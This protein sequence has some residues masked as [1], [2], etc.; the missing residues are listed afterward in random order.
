[1]IAH[2]EQVH[3]EQ[4]AEHSSD[5]EAHRRRLRYPA[6]HAVIQQQEADSA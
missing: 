3:A 1:M 2:H 6:L 5:V 4:L